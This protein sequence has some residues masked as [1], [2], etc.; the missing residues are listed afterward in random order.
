MIFVGFQ[1]HQTLSLSVWALIFII[2]YVHFEQMVDWIYPA[3]LPLNKANSSD[4][5]A[6]FLDINLSISIFPLKFIISGTI[7]ISILIYF[8]S[9]ALMLM[10]LHLFFSLEHILTLVTSIG[11]IRKMPTLKPVHLA[12]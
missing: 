6:P 4:T 8:I 3:E 9:R 7:S 5:E 2:D 11:L 10:S 12:L 1:V